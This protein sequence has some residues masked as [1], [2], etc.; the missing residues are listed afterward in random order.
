VTFVTGVLQLLPR[1]AL[2]IGRARQNEGLV[3]R[4]AH[5]LAPLI[6]LRSKPSCVFNRQISQRNVA[7]RRTHEVY[8]RAADAFTA[9]YGCKLIVEIVQADNTLSQLPM[10]RRLSSF[11]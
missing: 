8:W 6:L 3:S 10:L 1:R 11:C 9:S 4:L 7:L 5:L 2:A